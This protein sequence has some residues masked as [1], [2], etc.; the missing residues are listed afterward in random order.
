MESSSVKTQKILSHSKSA[1]LIAS[2]KPVNT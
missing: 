2:E 1:L